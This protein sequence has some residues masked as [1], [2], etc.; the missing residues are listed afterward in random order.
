MHTTQQMNALRGLAGC[1][2]GVE[3]TSELSAVSQRSA[4]GANLAPNG[5]FLVQRNAETESK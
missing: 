5:L 4:S 2:G 1:S 3:D